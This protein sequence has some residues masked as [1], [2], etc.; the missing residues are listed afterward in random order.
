MTLTVGSLFSGVG[1]FDL[2]FERAGMAVRWQCEKDTAARSVLRRHWPDV[3]VYED[4]RD[5]GIGAE[6]VDVVCGGFPCQ[7]VSIAGRR[8]GLAGERSGLW[9]EF[10]RVIRE[11]QPEW[12]VIENVPGLLSSNGGKDIAVILDTLEQLGYTVDCD[13]L[14]S[15]NFGVPQRRRRVFLVCQHVGRLAQR[16]TTSSAQTIAQCLT[17]ILHSILI[18]ARHRSLIGYMTSTSESKLSVDGMRK[19]MALFGLAQGGLLQ[20]WR[21]SLDAERARFPLES[22][23]LAS[24]PGANSQGTSSREADTWFASMCGATAAQSAEWNTVPSWKSILD[25]L[26]CLSNRFTTSTETNW[27]TESTIYTCARTLLNIAAFTCLSNTSSPTYWSLASSVSTAIREYTNYARQASNSLFTG[28]EWIQPWINFV[29]QAERLL[30][31]C[32]DL[33]TGRAAEVLFEREGGGG[34]PAPGGEAGQGITASPRG[35]AGSGGPAGDEAYNLVAVDFR[36]QT[37]GDCAPTLQAK[38]TGGYSLNYTPG[39]IGTLAAGDY[40]SATDLVSDAHHPAIAFEPR[41]YSG[42]ERMGGA[43]SSVTG[44]LK[45][46]D[47]HVGDSQQHVAGTTAPRRLTPLECERLQG[48]P[49]GWTAGQSDAARYRQMGNAV[50]VNVAEWIGRRIVEAQL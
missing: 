21:E 44:P 48:F 7:D 32:I 39:V 45:A 26:S 49:D 24:V 40:K 14:N 33:G 10:A 42:R 15:Q 4:V 47:T 27:I 8:A 13:I 6:A 3:T 50:T 9:F 22:S 35:I 31:T 37:L 34:H 30:D 12:V 16:K 28:L 17:E 29:G 20:N 25:G 43:P 18:A 38:S 19:R 2:G 5:V 1:G 41:Y 46:S 36:N 23:I 11:T